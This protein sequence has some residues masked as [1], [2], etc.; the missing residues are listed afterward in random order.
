MLTQG[1][2]LFEAEQQT[3]FAPVMHAWWNEAEQVFVQSDHE[4]AEPVTV[5]NIPV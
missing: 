3:E 1:R 4:N 5:V 2:S